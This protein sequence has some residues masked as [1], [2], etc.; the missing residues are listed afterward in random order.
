MVRY[1]DTPERADTIYSRL[2]KQQIDDLRRYPYREWEALGLTT[3]ISDRASKVVA[4][5][6]D[7]ET[8]S[9]VILSLMLS[10][11]S[12]SKHQFLHAYRYAVWSILSSGNLII[13]HRRPNYEE[14]WIHVKSTK[15]VRTN[16]KI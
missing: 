11:K 14:L 15:R 10:I 8:P 13:Y 7:R 2:T 6:L 9:N 5:W 12:K 3:R 4:E 16:A 1:N